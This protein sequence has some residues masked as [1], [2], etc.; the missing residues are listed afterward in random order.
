MLYQYRLKSTVKAIDTAVEDRGNLIDLTDEALE[1]SAM[2]M[3]QSREKQ[4]QIKRK[5]VY[6]AL[7]FP[8]LVP[9]PIPYTERSIL[10]HFN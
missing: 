4:N 8:P 5:Y 6:F 3:Q 9:Y 7:L 2:G 1:K 10:P